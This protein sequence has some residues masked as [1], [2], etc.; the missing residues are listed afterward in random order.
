M[1]DMTNKIALRFMT[2]SVAVCFMFMPTTVDAQ[3][4]PG[5]AD[6]ADLV[7]ESRTI[8]IADVDKTRRIRAEDAPGLAPD[9]ARLL[10]QAKTAAVVAAAR[11]VPA[12]MRYLVD[13]RRN[14]RGR[15]PDI[16][17]ARV[18][19]FLGA[20]GGPGEYALAHKYGQ[21]RWSPERESLVKRYAASRADPELVALKPERV[22]SAFHVPGSLPGES[23]SQIFVETE[24]GRPMSLVVLNRP[25]E[26]PRYAVS[27]G[28][29]IDTNAAPPEPGSLVALM[30]ACE[31]PEDLP[32]GIAMSGDRAALAADYAFV[33]AELGSCDRNF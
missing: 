27:T 24:A 26:T 19:L 20:E 25:G 18:I 10:V 3:P 6:L 22:T 2:A 23:E 12:E 29:I 4:V 14:D 31:L 17:G 11:S 13:L 32:D 33:R 5:N 8:V 30:L 1:F 15:A 21:I 28:D 7:T 9:F 16:E